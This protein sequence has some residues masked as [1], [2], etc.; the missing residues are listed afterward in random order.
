ML[1]TRKSEDRGRADHGWLK[2]RHTFSFADYYD[3]KQMGFHTLRVINEDRVAGGMGF[4]T[5]PHHDMEIISYVISGS[6]EHQ[7]SMGNK[8]VIRPDEVQVM[9][10]GTGVKHSEYNHS[11]T[12][13]AHFLQ[14]W[15]LPQ[16]KGIDPHYAQR[17]FKEEFQKQKLVLV[18]SKDARRGSNRIHQAADIYIGKLDPS[19][20]IKVKMQPSHHGWIQLI[21]G[22]LEVNGVRLDQGD[23]LAIT[24]EELLTITASAASEFMF[25]DLQ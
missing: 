9:S 16:S 14:I 10:A 21:K 11:K 6:L 23:G 1:T 4:D 13:E 12:Q 19:D 22:A 2:S 5:H 24:Q 8:T 17:S 15:I 18:A 20:V 25:F 3:P 7:D